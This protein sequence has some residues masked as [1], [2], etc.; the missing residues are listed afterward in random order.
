MR[1]AHKLAFA[2]TLWLLLVLPTFAF[3]SS[4]LAEAPAVQ[5][6]QAAG[7]AAVG[8]S[9]CGYYKVL[10]SRDIDRYKVLIYIDQHD[11]GDCINKRNVIHLNAK[12]VDRFAGTEIV[13]VHVPVWRTPTGKLWFGVLVTAPFRFCFNAEL[14]YS[15][16]YRALQSVLS[17]I[18]AS[19]AAIVAIIAA[20]WAGIIILLNSYP[21]LIPV[22]G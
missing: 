12:L 21:Y 11:L 2:A 18:H 20:V 8:D 22:L 7:A 17:R 15:N 6:D 1:T 10:L 3:A 19:Q 14:T 13:N 5:P 4:E 16:V 9:V